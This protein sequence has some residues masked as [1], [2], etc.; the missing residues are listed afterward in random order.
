M[1]TYRLIFS[2]DD[3]GV[4]RTVEFDAADVSQAMA[5]AREEARDRSAELWSER[6]RVH[7]ICG[8]ARYAEAPRPEFS[9]A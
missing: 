2:D 9:F 6:Q 5:F 1:H 4:A 8:S 3:R 7:R